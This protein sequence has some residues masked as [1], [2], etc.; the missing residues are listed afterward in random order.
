MKLAL[1][2]EIIQNFYSINK[3]ICEE[4]LQ[5]IFPA[6]PGLTL[7][8]IVYQER[9]RYTKKNYYRLVNAADKHY[10]FYRTAA[11]SGEPHGFLLRYADEIGLAPSLLARLVLQKHFEHVGED[12]SKQRLSE[13]MKD[14]TTINDST[15]SVETFYC[16]LNDNSYGPIMDVMRH[17][18]GLEYEM[19][20]KQ[21]LRELGLVFVDEE[22]LRERGYDKTPDVK[23]EVPVVIGDTVVTWIESKALFG[24][25]ENHRT[26]VKE[27]YRSYWNRFG[28]GLVI[29][30]FGYIEELDKNGEDGILI[31]DS[32][33]TDIKR[34]TVE[35]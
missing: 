3:R 8:C 7:R 32:I 33:P 27:Q 23:L 22:I 30:W 26:Y 34:M 1:Y 9:Q 16:I 20:L 21:D 25:V 17:S 28:R 31:R 2:K 15:L 19:K 5:K 6:V 11:S 24:D 4:E 10:D 18:V 29:Y 12:S 35:M 14:T 13:A